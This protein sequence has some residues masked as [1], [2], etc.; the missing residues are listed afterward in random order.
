MCDFGMTASVQYPNCS[1]TSVA[2]YFEFRG[3]KPTQHDLDLLKERHRSR[4][5]G[6]PFADFITTREAPP[7]VVMSYQKALPAAVDGTV[8]HSPPAHRPDWQEYVY[9]PGAY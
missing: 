9:E 4:Y 7:G 2:F 5:E 6:E 1:L 3:E 8:V